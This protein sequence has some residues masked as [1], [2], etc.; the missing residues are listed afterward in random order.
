VAVV[1]VNHIVDCYEDSTAVA[2]AM[3]EQVRL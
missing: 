2:I 3:L 1:L